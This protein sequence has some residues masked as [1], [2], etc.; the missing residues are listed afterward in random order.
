MDFDNTI[1]ITYTMFGF[2]EA[3]ETS[4][5]MDVSDGIYEKLQN[6]EDE[7][8]MLDSEFISDEMPG[9]HRKILKAIR[10]N[11]EEESWNPND[12]TVEKRHPGGST[13]RE[14]CDGASHLLM[15]TYDDDDYI[16][17]T[18]ELLW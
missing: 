2:D 8:E 11:M 1:I 3:G 16:E 14:K 12:G 17:Y 15:L 5:E 13:Y 9:I 6:A 7:G 4:F 10:E 18:V